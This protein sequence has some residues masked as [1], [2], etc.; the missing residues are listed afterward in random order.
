MTGIFIL[1]PMPFGF[2][3]TTR[4]QLSIL[5]NCFG[6]SENQREKSILKAVADELSLRVT[7]KNVELLFHA[8]HSN[9][10]RMQSK[11]QM[12]CVCVCVPRCQYPV[13]RH[14][15][16]NASLFFSPMQ[17]GFYKWQS[18]P[19]ANSPLASLD[20]FFSVE[21]V[22]LC[23]ACQRTHMLQIDLLRQR[24][25][26]T[27]NS[28]YIGNTREQKSG[29]C[30]KFARTTAPLSYSSSHSPSNDEKKNVAKHIR[31][32]KK[33]FRWTYGCFALREFSGVCIYMSCMSEIKRKEKV[34]ADTYFG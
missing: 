19:K 13:D 27:G 3:H 16:V 18:I 4:Q 25:R 29:I 9:A 1:H 26:L 23:R 7:N 31:K 17:N 34:S 21:C 5:L 32:E 10:P 15:P 14:I 8:A 33:T 2:T 12:P 20:S 11:L 30:M 6:R 28:E 24:R 22:S